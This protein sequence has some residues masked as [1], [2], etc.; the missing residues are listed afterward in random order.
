D[1][2]AVAV[3]A[4]IRSLLRPAKLASS[5]AQSNQGL[6]GAKGL[7]TQP[8]SVS[9]AFATKGRRGP[10]VGFSSEL[11]PASYLGIP[12]LYP[13]ARRPARY[14]FHGRKIRH[15]CCLEMRL[16]QPAGGRLGEKEIDHEHDEISHRPPQGA[17]PH[18]P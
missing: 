1:L 11:R 14:R 3:A 4:G 2:T 18:G 17:R 13:W 15:I 5:P 12:V 10:V 7:S 8:Q 9:G 6:A 16:V